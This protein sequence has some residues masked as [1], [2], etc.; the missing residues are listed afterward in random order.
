MS[1][2]GSIATTVLAKGASKLLGGGSKRPKPEVPKM[3][4][5]KTRF[6]KNLRSS[7]V[8][9]VRGSTTSQVDRLISRHEAIMSSFNVEKGAVAGKY[10]SLR[11]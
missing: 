6:S 1:L 8:E 2:W 7:P 9:M 3:R 10:G 4:A 11:I 5:T